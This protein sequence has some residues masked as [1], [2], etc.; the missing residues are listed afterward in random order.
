MPFYNKRAIYPLI[1]PAVLILISA[2]LVWKWPDLTREGEG[3]KEINAFILI[4]PLLPYAFFAIV[5]VLGWR[6][7]N[8][9]IILTSLVFALLYF[10]VSHTTAAQ[11]MLTPSWFSTSRFL[12][13]LNL[14]FFATLMKRRTLTPV[15]ILCLLLI[16]LEAFVVTFS[17]RAAG[18]PSPQTV[19]KM[20]ALFPF[21]S[22]HLISFL[23]KIHAA[24]NSHSFLGLDMI[25]ILLLAAFSAAFI[26]LI[27]WF[28]HHR[29]ATSAGSLGSLVA[30][31]FALAGNH[32]GPAPVLF[33]AAA[34]LILIVTT[35]ESSFSMAYMDDLTG[36]AG[37][38]SLNQELLN[39]GKRYCIA[40]IDIDHFKK[41]NDTYGHKTGDQVLKMIASKLKQMT[42][43]AKVFRYGGEEFTAIFP[44]KSTEDCLPH[45][46]VYRK[47]IETA[48]FVVRG[49]D[50]GKGSSENRGK[51][52]ADGQKRV[53]VTVSIGIASPERALT[54]P[55]AVLKEADKALYKAKKRGRNRVET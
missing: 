51:R 36:L 54:N 45:L 38:R 12:L 33:F 24:L 44:G 49:K 30:S 3:V 55:E 53:K 8:S 46:E 37:R 11:K 35:V 6:F 25:S 42:G 2:I 23:T 43:G 22:G 48:H 15:G 34:G 5:I 13:P 9:G 26:F 52:K 32:S 41:F 20:K 18:L 28:N 21:L 1:L 39:L 31:S 40:M 16:L 7:G 14:A 29:D 47:T 4:L 19:V 50:R 10:A 17:S 27:L